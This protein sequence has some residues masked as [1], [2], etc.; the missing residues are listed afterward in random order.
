[1]KK[2]R[3]II[4]PEERERRLKEILEIRRNDP[5]IQAYKQRKKTV[6]IN[7][8]ILHDFAY[9]D[10]KWREAFYWFENLCKELNIEPTKSSINGIDAKNYGQSVKV[11]SY[12][13][14]RKKLEE[15]N[16]EQ[17]ETLSVICMDD[18]Q[19]YAS[20]IK[21]DF[22]IRFEQL[23]G[24]TKSYSSTMFEESLSPYLSLIHI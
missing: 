14:G 6:D 2:V 5:V 1:M 15:Y 23:S 22:S 18:K 19:S 10:V 9:E 17:I 8:L 11:M 20:D 3:E 4:S 24:S 21:A 7:M 12:R 16:F 13:G